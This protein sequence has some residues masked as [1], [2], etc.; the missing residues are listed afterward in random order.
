MPN[1][2]E[3][4]CPWCD[5]LVLGDPTSVTIGTSQRMHAKCHKEWTEE[6]DRLHFLDL[7]AIYGAGKLHEWFRD[8]LPPELKP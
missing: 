1:L 8:A 6:Q 4:D 5:E 3:Y 2:S 7:L